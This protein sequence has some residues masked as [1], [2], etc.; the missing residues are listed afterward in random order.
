MLAH[1]LSESNFKE[2]LLMLQNPKAM[3]TLG[4][5]RSIEQVKAN[6]KW[7][8]K[9]W[10]DNGFGLWIFYDKSTNELIG[11]GGLRR[12]VI[13]DVEEIEL[14]FALLPEFW[15]QGYA[16][17]IAQACI[18]IAFE[19]I[20]LDNI[21]SFTLTSNLKSQRVMEKSGFTLEKNIELHGEPHVLY[22]LN[23]DKYLS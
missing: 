13:S 5:I 1:R 22:R 17:E 11:R 14:G 15:Q 23:S 16:T 19:K 4:G 8:L 6:L 3:E 10:D 2:L 20:K 9:Q 21:V 18:K 12:V 7:N